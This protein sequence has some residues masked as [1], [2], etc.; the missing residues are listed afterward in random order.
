MLHHHYRQWDIDGTLVR[1]PG[2]GRRAMLAAGRQLFGEHFA[3]PP[4]LDTAGWIDLLIWRE[5]ARHNGL[6]AEATLEDFRSTYAAQLREELSTRTRAA[7]LPGVQALIERLEGVSGL[8]Q[9]LLTGNFPEAGRLKLDA[10]GIDPGRFGVCAWGHEAETR[11]ELVPLALERHRETTGHAIAP[12]HVVIIGDTPRDV[13][14][15]RHSGCR[16]IAV[17]TGGFDRSALERAGADLAVET[18]ADSQPILEFILG[19]AAARAA[20]SEAK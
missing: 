18:L 8:T 5:T 10:A 12:E 1:S 17:A 2:A 3:T 14:C 4:A 19:A 11:R 6:D 13:D 20:Q 9:G 16:C 7:A 15:A